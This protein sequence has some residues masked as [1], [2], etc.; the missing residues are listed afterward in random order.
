MWSGFGIAR[1]RSSFVTSRDRQEGLRQRIAALGFDQVRFATVGP[2]PGDGLR[3]WLKSGY[4]ADMDWME[5]TAA[6]RLQPDLVLPG[7]RSIIMLGVSYSGDTWPAAG[8]EDS[9]PIWARYA[10]HADYH[11][12]LRPG[13]AAAGKILEELYGITRADYRYYVDT[14]PV[15][16]R[17]WAGRA[18]LGFV[19]KN[20]MLISRRHGNWIFLSA[21]LTRVELIPDPAIS[22]RLSRKAAAAPNPIGLLCGKCTR[23]LD[24]CPTRAFA[25]PGWSIPGCASLTRRLKTAASFPGRF[26]PG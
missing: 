17:E 16:E 21:L 20:A 6:K 10:L 11:D 4:Q 15:L 22:N 12:S 1:R 9:A 7:A 5:R 13:L 24:A 8:K 23:C 3:R 26:A 2:V 18:G 25:A 14:G 19:G